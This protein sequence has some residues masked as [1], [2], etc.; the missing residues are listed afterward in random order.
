MKSIRIMALATI[1]VSSLVSVQ[2]EVFADKEPLGTEKGRSM[3]SPICKER[4]GG[5]V[6]LPPEGTTECLLECLSYLAPEN[7]RAYLH[8]CRDGYGSRRDCDDAIGRLDGLATSCL[9]DFSIK[10]S[11]GRTFGGCCKRD[12]PGFASK[13]PSGR[14]TAD[15]AS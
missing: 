13:P 6:E 12:A 10:A 8:F 9:H 11:R 14:I 2:T 7:Y 15:K 5:A 1:M 4:I 3:F